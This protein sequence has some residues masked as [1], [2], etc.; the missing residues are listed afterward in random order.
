MLITRHGRVLLFCKYVPVV[1]MARN[2]KEI[3]WYLREKKTHF[4]EYELAK[5]EEA[6]LA[7]P[8][9]SQWSYR[10]EGW[11]VETLC[12]LPRLQVQYIC[13]FLITTEL[14]LQCILYKYCINLKYWNL[15][16][17]IILRLNIIAFYGGRVPCDMKLVEQRCSRCGIDRPPILCPVDSNELL[18]RTFHCIQHIHKTASRCAILHNTVSASL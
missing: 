14:C 4:K 18:I 16:C 11:G 8:V 2:L 5:I 15:M 6:W 7:D 9:M 3:G 13:I 10:P 12:Y 17:Y 1:K